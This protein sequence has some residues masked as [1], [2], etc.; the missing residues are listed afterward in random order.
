M[1]MAKMMFESDGYNAEN[2]SLEM[3]IKDAYGID[4]LQI[5]GAPQWIYSQKYDIEATLDSSSADQISKLTENQR[6]LIHQRIL[7]QFLSDRFKLTIHHE[8]KDLPVYWLVNANNGPK[9]HQGEGRG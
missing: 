8:T 2:T 4:D 7:Q 9:L 6:K 3:L 5:S 1:G